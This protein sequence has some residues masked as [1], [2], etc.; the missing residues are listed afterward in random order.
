MN[1][2]KKNTIVIL[3]LIGVCLV[4]SGCGAGNKELKTSLYLKK[5][6]TTASIIINQASACTNLARSY[7]VT[8]EYAKVSGIDF[9]QAMRE[10]HGQSTTE[11][12]IMMKSNKLDIDELMVSLGDPPS[13]CEEIHEMIKAMHQKY[14]E[15]HSLVLELP[16]DMEKFQGTVIDLENDLMEL[17]EGLESL[18]INL[19]KQ[20]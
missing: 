5:A 13:G 17:S 6:E 11:N 16:D 2:Y 8:W 15:I 18:L 4:L 20:E 19:D 7:M 9:T 3:V 14:S 10:M 1:R 12:K